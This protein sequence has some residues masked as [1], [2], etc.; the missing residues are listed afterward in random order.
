MT[1]RLHRSARSQRSTHH[2]HAASH[3][4][5]ASF[6]GALEGLLRPV[7]GGC[8]ATILCGLTYPEILYAPKKEERKRENIDIA[9]RRLSLS[10]LRVKHLVTQPG[11][12]PKTRPSHLTTADQV[13]EV[14]LKDSPSQTTKAESF[15]G[16]RP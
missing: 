1:S 9:W 14:S 10:S 4:R 3:F 7:S 6:R 8:T 13:N 12:A 5:P 15:R 2:S 11:N 16:R